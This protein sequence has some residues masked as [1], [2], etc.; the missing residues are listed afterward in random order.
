ME[1]S[2][3][4]EIKGKSLELNGEKIW[5]DLDFEPE[6]SEDEMDELG[7]LICCGCFNIIQVSEKE[8]NRDIGPDWNTIEDSAGC[9]D[10]SD[11]IRLG[12]FCNEEYHEPFG[13]SVEY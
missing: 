11:Y 8:M 1:R 9:C 5:I 3:P 2:I 12:V 13:V 6:I 4:R 7:L 10:Q